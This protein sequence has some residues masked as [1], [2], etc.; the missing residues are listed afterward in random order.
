MAFQTFVLLAIL[1]ACNSLVLSYK[2]ES[3]NDLEWGLYKFKYQKV[4]KTSEEESFRKSIWFKN[5]LYIENFNKNKN[6]NDFQVAINALSDRSIE[7]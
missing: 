6:Q 4:Y 2:I 3:G 7:V 5:K 1:L